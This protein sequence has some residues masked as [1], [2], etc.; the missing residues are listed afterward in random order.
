MFKTKKKCRPHAKL[1]A[2][3]PKKR[4]AKRLKGYSYTYWVLSI[5]EKKQRETERQYVPQVLHA[6]EYGVTKEWIDLLYAMDREERLKVR[7]GNEK[8][9]QEI[10]AKKASTLNPETDPVENLPDFSFAPKS[11]L[12]QEKLSK[13]LPS[14]KLSYL[15]QTYLQPQQQELI[16][17]YYI[18]EIPQAT[19]ARQDGVASSSIDG[20]R[21]RIYKRLRKKFKEIY[22]INDYEDLQDQRK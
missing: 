2:V 9:D 5:P 14:G 20:R 3:S 7:Y 13:A 18:E 4:P 12:F 8:K 6:G 22:Q 11:Q 19:I 17:R 10:E 1:V 21:N 15:I 16:H